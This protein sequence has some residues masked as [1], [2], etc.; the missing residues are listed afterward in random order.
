MSLWYDPIQDEIWLYRQ[1]M[2]DEWVYEGPGFYSPQYTLIPPWCGL[3]YI[4]EL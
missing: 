4:G 3:A 2:L 1:R